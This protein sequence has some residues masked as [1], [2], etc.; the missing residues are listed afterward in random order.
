AERAGH[1]SRVRVVTIAAALALPRLAAAAEAGHA[2]HV[3]S[4]G[5]LL[6]PVVN[7]AIF[8]FIFVTYALPAL[9]EYLRRRSEDAATATREAA[10]ALA[11]ATD[12]MTALERRRS[13]L[14]GER[15]SIVRDLVDTATQQAGRLQA[16]AEESG[17]RRRA[18]AELVATQERQRALDAVRAEVAK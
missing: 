11:A 10:A 15:D 16:Q 6:F 17:A 14:A 13:A 3:P 5:D 1:R 8:A 18:D 7:F 2:H 4:I 9:R 12:A